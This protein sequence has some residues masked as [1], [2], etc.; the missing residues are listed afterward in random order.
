MAPSDQ[1]QNLTSLLAAD[2]D[3]FEPFQGTEMLA[4]SSSV[5]VSV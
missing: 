4:A 5:A 1:K 3:T 2:N